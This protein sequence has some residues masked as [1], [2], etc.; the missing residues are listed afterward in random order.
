[1]QEKKATFE[2]VSIR[3]QGWQIF[4]IKNKKGMKKKL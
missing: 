1:M 3:K 2:V 4:I